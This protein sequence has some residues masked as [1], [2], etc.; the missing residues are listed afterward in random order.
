M[1]GNRC[2]RRWWVVVATVLTLPMAVTACDPSPPWE[3]V[4]AV[5]R[6]PCVHELDWHV[7]S[8][9]QPSAPG[10]VRVFG[11]S[12]C[13]PGEL[14]I[15]WADGRLTGHQASEAGTIV[16]HKRRDLVAF[17]LTVER[18]SGGCETL[19]LAVATQQHTRWTE[20]C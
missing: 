11:P 5:G 1:I 12:G 19:H 17:S 14:R 7:G 10:W 8:V 15:R 3:G 13:A 4:F 18:L 6:Q 9:E 20:P 2:V 16:H